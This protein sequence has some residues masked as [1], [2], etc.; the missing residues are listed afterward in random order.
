MLQCY[1]LTCCRSV[2]AF[3][4]PLE[5]SARGKG[6]ARPTQRPALSGVHERASIL[7]YKC[8]V[9]PVIHQTIKMGLTFPSKCDDKIN[10]HLH[11][12]VQLKF[13]W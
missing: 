4:A 7:H 9:S 3:L 13:N 2:T 8:T 10:L 1:V 5:V 11:G 6:P 12:N